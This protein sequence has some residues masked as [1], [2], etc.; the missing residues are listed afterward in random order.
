MNNELNGKILEC[1][2]QQI[3]S[4]QQNPYNYLY[5]ND[6]QSE[7]FCSLRKSINKK[8]AVTNSIE[9][10]VVNTEYYNK[11]DIV[12]L[13]TEFKVPEGRNITQSLVN[14]LYNQKM[15]LAIEIKYTKL[16]R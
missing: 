13:D 6:I 12:C 5:E 3:A 7:L 4:F 16:N 9:I 2:N 10:D 8:I 11:I 15:Y 14:A 1:I